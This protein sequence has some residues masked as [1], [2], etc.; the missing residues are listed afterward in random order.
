[1][2]V[3]ITGGTGFIGSRLVK[4]HLELGDEVRVLSR[5]SSDVMNLSNNLK[6]FSGDLAEV[7]SLKAFTDGADVLYHCA[8]EILDESRMEAVHVEGTKRLTDAASGRIGRWVQLSSTGAYGQKR[9][10]TVTE[11]TEL[12]PSGTYEVTKVKAD[13]LV[14]AASSQGAFEYVILRPS[15]V[16]GAG[17]P[18]QSLYGLIRM[19]ERGWFFYIGRPETA[20]ANYIHVDN[21][22]KAMNLCG[23]SPTALGQAFVL[24]DHRSL[25]QFVNHIAY[26]L[27]TNRPKVRLPEWQVRFLVKL[28][29]N[30]PSLPLTQT[31]IDALTTSV[32]YSSEHIERQIGYVHNVSMEEGLGELVRYWQHGHHKS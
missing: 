31:R 32:V 1:M 11:K 24:S 6:W 9:E 21:V 10:G 30:I 15:I 19:I 12:N 5:Q 13:R 28:F 22:V 29:G 8:G 27:G 3:A 25:E 18:N 2:K 20:N 16:Y 4:L 7:G 17:M 26:L 23:K 14:E